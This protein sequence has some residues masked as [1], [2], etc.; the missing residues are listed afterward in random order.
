MLINVEIGD[1]AVI[2]N[3]SVHQEN[4]I[5]SSIVL[6]LINNYRNVYNSIKGE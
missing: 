5:Q 1:V 6:K 2:E 4:K 3:K